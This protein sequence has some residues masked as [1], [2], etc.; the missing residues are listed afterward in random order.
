MKLHHKK[1]GF[2]NGET[3]NA[4]MFKKELNI[5]DRRFPFGSQTHKS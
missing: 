1:L 4:F 3:A 5:Q 2:A